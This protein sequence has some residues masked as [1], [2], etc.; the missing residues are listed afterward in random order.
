MLI[1]KSNFVQVD[2]MAWN[3][4]KN[5]MTPIEPDRFLGDLVLRYQTFF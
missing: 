1:H 5:K 3:V 4:L 2:E